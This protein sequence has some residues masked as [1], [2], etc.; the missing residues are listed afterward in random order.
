MAGLLGVCT[1][2]QTVLCVSCGG[3]SEKGG[4]GGPRRKMLFQLGVY[5]AKHPQAGPWPR[6]QALVGSRGRHMAKNCWEVEGPAPLNLPHRG[7]GTS[8]NSPHKV[9]PSDAQTSAAPGWSSPGGRG[10][11]WLM[12]TSRSGWGRSRTSSQFGGAMG[13]C[14]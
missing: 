9:K 14:S 3:Q 8:L 1:R 12:L 5:L 10:G 11:G 13:Q 4:Q 7:R 6:Q 2:P